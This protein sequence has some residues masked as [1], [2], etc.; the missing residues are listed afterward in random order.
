[1]KAFVTIIRKRM[2]AGL[3]VAVPLGITFLVLRLLYRFTAGILT[4]MV[5]NLFGRLPESAVGVLSVLVLVVL[6]Y[7]IGL[8]A[9]NL[10]GR[11]L[12]AWGERLFAR[13]PI[14]GAIYSAV[15]QVVEAVGASDRSAIKSV[16][17]LEFPHRSSYTV[18]FL[19]GTIIDDQGRNLA[20]IIVPTSPNPATGFFVLVPRAEVR[21]LDLSV[22]DA[23]K[24]VVSGGIIA[25]ERLA[26]RSSAATSYDESA[27]ESSA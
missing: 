9:A 4:P 17:M 1:M 22:E 15:K 18:G 25:P 24:L 27:S 3:L 26:R 16:V 6:L 8:I 12:I 21:E 19:V 23:I 20:K 2:T 10:L 14:A 7:L 5:R 13:V 11:R